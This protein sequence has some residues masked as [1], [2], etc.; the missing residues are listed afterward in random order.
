MKRPTLKVYLLDNVT[1]VIRLVD[2]DPPTTDRIR[3]LRVRVLVSRLS[4]A[5]GIGKHS[6]RM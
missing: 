3:R 2:A 4:H 5:H 1:I 6:H